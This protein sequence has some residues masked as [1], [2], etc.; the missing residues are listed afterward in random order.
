MNICFQLTPNLETGLIYI[1]H[2]FGQKIRGG[3]SVKRLIK[4]NDDVIQKKLHDIKLQKKANTNEE[5]LPIELR[6][7]MT[8]TSPRYVRVNQ[9]KPDW[10]DTVTTILSMPGAV[11]DEHIDHLYMFPPNTDFHEHPLVLSGHIILQDKASCFPAYIL[12]KQDRKHWGDAIDACAAPGNKTSH[13]ASIMVKI[14]I[15]VY[16]YIYTLHYT[17]LYE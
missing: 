9:L 6:S 13:L 2:L 7:T 5:L 3:G 16:I 1:E 14:N 15:H 4:E 11:A 10:K 12:M 17:T 8:H